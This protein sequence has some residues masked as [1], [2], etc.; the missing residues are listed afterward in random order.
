MG[1]S[2]MSSMH[3]KAELIHYLTT[4]NVAPK[5]KTIAK[6]AKGNTL[7]TVHEYVEDSGCY[8]AGCR[9]IG[10]YLLGVEKGWWGY[11]DMDESMGPSEL[12]CP[13]RFFDMVPCPSGEWAAP[14][15]ERVK[16]YQARLAQFKGLKLGTKVMLKKGL[17]ISGVPLIEAV[18]TSTRP[19][20]ARAEGYTFRLPKAYIEAIL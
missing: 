12:S 10:C 7:W 19:L 16:A 9:W 13:V 6:C 18:I 15:R 8:K 1:W 14:W 11:K 2:F 20:N 17:T 5:M 4:T 3:S